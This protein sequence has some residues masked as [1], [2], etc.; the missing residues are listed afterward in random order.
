MQACARRARLVAYLAEHPSHETSVPR[1]SLGA[2][3]AADLGLL[4]CSLAG[5]VSV[6]LFAGAARARPVVLTRTA[7]QLCS[8]SISYW[9][10]YME[11]LAVQRFVVR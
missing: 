11:S 4:S 9:F 8:P 1:T 10:Q 2:E 3:F 6:A 5:G 7:Q